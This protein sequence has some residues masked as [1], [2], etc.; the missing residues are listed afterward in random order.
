MMKSKLWIAGFFILVAIPLGIVA[1]L[2]IKVD[3]YFHYHEPD[4]ST[5]Y[6]TIY[7]QRS[8]NDG[9]LHHFD[10]EGVITGTSMTENFLT[11]EA[12]QLFGCNFVKIPFSGGTFNEINNNLKVALSTHPNLKVIIRGLDMGKFIEDKDAIREDLGEYPTYLYNENPFDDVQ[13]LFNRDVVFKNVYEM[14]KARRSSEF[15]P[16][17]TSFDAY[18]NWMGKFPFGVNA[19]FPDG[20][21]VTYYNVAQE[22][23]TED[24]ERMVRENVRQNVTELAEQYPDVTFYYFFTPYSAAWWQMLINAGTFDKQ[25][26]AEQIVIEEILKTPNIKL[27]SFN[28]LTDITTDLN[29]YKDIPHY[30]G[31]INSLILK[32]IKDGTGL[33]TEDNYREY[34]SKEKDFYGS[35]DYQKCFDEQEDYEKDYYAAALLDE[36]IYGIHPYHLTEKDVPETVLRNA[37]IV[38][39][40]HDGEFG[41]LC[42]GRLDRAPGEKVSVS[43]YIRDNDDYNGARITIDEIGPYRY[44]VVYGKKNA[45]MGQP[46]IYLY[47]QDGKVLAQTTAE[48]KKLDDQW[49]QY[50]IDVS[51]FNG[52]VDIVLQGGY[53][54]NTGREGSEFVFSDITLY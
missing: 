43:D 44:L 2:T 18:S 51:A 47:D 14:L 50:M 28:D 17:I 40:Q 11:S 53:I 38:A 16:G 23:L 29:H 52:K 22:E 25:I 45:D 8:Q 32:Y 20:T 26:R 10:Y 1:F 4:T 49:H 37:E 46:G 54:D 15:Q 27:Y 24:E 33:L 3:P 12:E 9:I 41:I 21:K 36:E 6:Y 35:F 19:L 7:N 5:Y 42:K 13:Y 30:A 39:D 31:W 34:L 48:Y